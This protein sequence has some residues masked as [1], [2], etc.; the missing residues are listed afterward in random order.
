MKLILGGINGEYLRDI[1]EAAHRE[2]EY[3]KAAVAYAN[4]EELLFEWCLKRGIP[5]TYWG[6]F[7]ETVPVS[8]RILEKFLKRQSPN[9]VCKLVRSFHPK[10]IWWQ[11]FGAYIGSANL[12]NAAWYNNVEA[13]CFFDEAELIAAGF[14]LQL[15]EFFEFIDSN[16]SPLTA[17]LYEL[18]KARAETLNQIRISDQNTAEAF[19]STNLVTPWSG[20]VRSSQRSIAEKS[21]AAFLEE[22]YDT[23]QI[24]RGI[25]SRVT[26]EEYRPR[27]VNPNTP[28]G[29]QADQF[30][31]AH[32]YERTFE[33]NRAQFENHFQD[34]KSNP[35]QALVSAMK[36]WSQLGT[37]PSNEDLTLNEY[38][39]LLREFHS[40]ERILSLTEDEFI[41][42][43]WRVHAIRDH[44]RR[45]AN[46]IVGLPAQEGSYRIEEKSAAFAR[47]LYGLKSNH[48]YSVLEVI[49]HVLYGGS[50]EDVPNRLWQALD[51]PAWKIEHLGVV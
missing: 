12:S 8:P 30:L 9:F 2:T 41:E 14:D 33:G 15:E 28:S 18:I 3:V 46:R 39:P 34:N 27:W 6:R 44:A 19:S 31:H 37:A 36:W 42:L 47:Y 48:G 35:E 43:C 29:A 21:Q 50:A 32:Y 10:V 13:G 51:D 26:T 7:D 5:I 45:V 40:E 1:V 38:A 24:L 25:A 17:E 20:V 22:W 49:R 23:L 16:S 4:S 11:G